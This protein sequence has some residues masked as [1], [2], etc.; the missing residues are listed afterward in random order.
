MRF[1]KTYSRPISFFWLLLGPFG[2]LLMTSLS[3][4]QP[5]AP[6]KG[7]E[8]VD[9][10]LKRQVLEV[11][12]NLDRVVQLREGLVVYSA[13]VPPKVGSR[14]M[15][16]R[17]VGDALEI[18]AQANVVAV[19]K[20]RVFIEVDKESIYKAPQ[21]GDM[22]SL[23]GRPPN[24]SDDDERRESE[25]KASEAPLPPEPGFVELLYGATSGDLAVSSSNR[26]NAFK[27]PAS[28]QLTDLQFRWYFEFLWRLGLSYKSWDGVFPTETYFRDI[29]ESQWSGNEMRFNFRLRR[30]S[31][32][33]RPTFF[34]VNFSE[35]F[36]TIN[37]DENLV[38]SRYSGLGLGVRLAGE[39]VSMTWTSDVKYIDFSLSEIFF[40]YTHLQPEIKDTGPI[41]RGSD[42][43]G[44]SGQE[45]R[46][47]ATAL[48]YVPWIPLFKRYVF[49]VE[50]SQRTYDIQFSGPTV[51]ENPDF[52]EIP[53]NGSYSEQFSQFRWM[54]GI[55][56]DDVIG[57]FLIPR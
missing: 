21:V 23:L 42:S 11:T 16:Q 25:L 7:L 18:L 32:Y 48:M 37:P 33:F 57:E 41:S 45:L 56:L 8:G 46:I 44:S 50:Y 35:E 19:Q 30:M 53:E 22:V 47:G 38:S 14:V 43:S 34:L 54:I 40:E 20:D 28:Y 49:S 13:K 2:C 12:K 26:T 10:D 52:F 27:G 36:Q 6:T 51:S 17:V 31:E 1:G 15:L 39:F 9:F 5:I 29:G 55:R 3:I 24:W 4:A